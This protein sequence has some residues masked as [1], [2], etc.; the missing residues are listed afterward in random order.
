[1]EDI[2]L[3][4]E[5]NQKSNDILINN[6]I[7]DNENTNDNENDKINVND[8]VFTDTKI[9]DFFKDLSITIGGSKLI[10]KILK[11]P[12]NNKELLLARQKIN[13]FISDSNKKILKNNEKDLLWIMTLDKELK[14]DLTINLLFY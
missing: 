7:D 11:T 13:N 14:E 9:C 2:N 12:I 3:I 8:N 10:E 1:M 6:I 4:F 5:I